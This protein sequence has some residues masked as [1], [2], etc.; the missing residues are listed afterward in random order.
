MLNCRH[1][2]DLIHVIEKVCER[3]FVMFQWLP[4][5]AR[6]HATS[7]DSEKALITLQKIAEENGKFEVL[8]ILNSSSFSCLCW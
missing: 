2:H 3:V 4:E 6:F 7:G 5:S 8:K 1:L